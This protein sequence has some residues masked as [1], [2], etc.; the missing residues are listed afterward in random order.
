MKSKIPHSDQSMFAF[1]KRSRWRLSLQ[2]LRH[3]A[4]TP[5]RKESKTASVVLNARKQKNS[6]SVR[7]KNCFSSTTLFATQR[8]P[9]IGRGLAPAVMFLCTLRREQAP[10]LRVL[11]HHAHIPRREENKTK[12]FILT[13]KLCPSSRL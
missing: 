2:V 12:I 5:R 8:I 1:S 9:F 4:Y 3:R 11:R 6:H 13:T 10:A 7:F